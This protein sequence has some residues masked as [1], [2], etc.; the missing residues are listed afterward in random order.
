MCCFSLKNAD[1]WDIF[2]ILKC[3][4]NTNFSTDSGIIL[5]FKD[6]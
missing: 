4:D 6:S 1:A 5:L 2:K 3:T